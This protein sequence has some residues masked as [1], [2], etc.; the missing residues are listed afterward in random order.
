M[1]IPVSGP[2][3]NVN[4]PSGTGRGGQTGRHSRRISPASS[5]LG[6]PPKPARPIPLA[7]AQ[8][9]RQRCWQMYLIAIGRILLDI[10]LK[11]WS[12]P[13]R[14]KVGASSRALA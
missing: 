4:D 6:D 7:M 5:V 14:G 8:D 9:G 13:R 2:T 3:G 10:R 1:T 11:P 12:K